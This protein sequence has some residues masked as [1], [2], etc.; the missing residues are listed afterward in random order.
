MKKRLIAMFAGVTL[1]LVGVV[2]APASPAA[3][4]TQKVG[5]R[6]G[7]YL[8]PTTGVYGISHVTVTGTA[9]APSANADASFSDNTQTA[10]VD[11]QGI[12]TNGGAVWVVVTY[13]CKVKV[14]PWTFPS[15]GKPVGGQRW[16]YGKP[17]QP[18]YNM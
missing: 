14:G 11:I 4:S 7:S 1:A 12:P 9:S 18:T 15:S 10:Y 6:V 2:V 5:F 8:C 3:A 17:P 16:V 13:H